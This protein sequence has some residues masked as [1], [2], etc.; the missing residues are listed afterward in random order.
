MK[1]VG[2][3]ILKD[4]GDKFQIHSINTIGFE[5]EAHGYV[6]GGLWEG[7]T[8]DQIA[9]N[10]KKAGFNSVRIPFHPKVFE[11]NKPTDRQLGIWT[12][13]PNRYLRGMGSVDL[14]DKYIEALEKPLF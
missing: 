5:V 12:G 4:N 2:R 1:I 10:I 13:S 9:A 14:L 3:D 6:L 7:I 11:N 8:F